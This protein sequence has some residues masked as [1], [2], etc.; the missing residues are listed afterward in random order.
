MDVTT[1]PDW[2]I[3]AK[4]TCRLYY[5]VPVRNDTESWGGLYSRLYYR[6]NQGS[7]LSLGDS[8]YSSVMLAG[9]YSIAYYGC[10]F[11]LDFTGET[12]DFTL[13]FLVQ[14]APYNNTTTVISSN[15]I[16]S[17]SGGQSNSNGILN[18]NSFYVKVIL[19]GDSIL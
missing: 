14:G 7:W 12:S 17:G 10:P 19:T 3:P 18:P 9:D 2:S 8:G 1:T 4:S 6:I 11:T 13:G 5:Q 16:G 15:N